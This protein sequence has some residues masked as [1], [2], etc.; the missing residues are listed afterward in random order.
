MVAGASTRSIGVCRA[1]LRRCWPNRLSQL[2][3]AGLVRRQ[4]LEKGRGYDYLL[5]EAGQELDPIITNLA[6]WGQ[7]WSCDLTTENLDPAF[8]AW[9]MHTR[10]STDAMPAGRTAI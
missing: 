9:S 8:L 4:P 6:V 2:E 7:R 1:F 10:M 3:H 5:T